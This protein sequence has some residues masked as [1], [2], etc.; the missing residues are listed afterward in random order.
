MSQRRQSPNREARIP[1]SVVLMTSGLII[2]LAVVA[3]YLLT[4][5]G[6]PG[7]PDLI[8]LAVIPT[9]PP[10]N[11][12]PAGAPPADTPLLPETPND[13]ANLPSEASAANAPRLF[14]GGGPGQPI[15]LVI[16][17][18]SVDAPVVG[19]GLE[20]V[21]VGEQRFYRWQVPPSYAAGWHNTS[22]PLGQ[23]GNTVLNGHHNVYGEVFRDLVNLA[24]GDEIVLYDENGS[25]SYRV[26]EQHILLERG[27]P[28]EVRLANAHWMDPT[29]DERITL[30][31]CWPY[32]DN[33]HRVII[34][35][36]PTP[37]GG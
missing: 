9:R 19:V 18:L 22:A 7:L 24:I 32:T 4:P 11:P 10:A 30:I 28:L 13:L 33:S 23:P 35:A 16:P 37:A 31:T 12:T 15:R 8:P 2:L 27:Q 3:I 36:Y 21:S 17:S 20:E 5:I 14:S 6:P 25:H 26:G 34:V 29:N 1:I